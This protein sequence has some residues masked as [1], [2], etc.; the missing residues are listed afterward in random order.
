[1]STIKLSILPFKMLLV[2]SGKKGSTLSETY[3]PH[4]HTKLPR[5]PKLQAKKCRVYLALIIRLGKV[6]SGL[7]GKVSE[8]RSG[9][10]HKELLTLH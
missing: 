2:E 9:H 1:M 6:W 7:P 4:L 5:E 8:A 10:N 3:A